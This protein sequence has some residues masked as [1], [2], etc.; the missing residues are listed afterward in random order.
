V[1]IS[2]GIKKAY[3]TTERSTQMQI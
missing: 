2:E 3:G 1:G